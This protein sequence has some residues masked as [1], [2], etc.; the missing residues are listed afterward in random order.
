MP[1]YMYS[2]LSHCTEIAITFDTHFIMRHGIPIMRHPL[3]F[4]AWTSNS[5]SLYSHV[6]D[7]G[8]STKFIQQKC[9]SKFKL[10]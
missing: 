6:L 4:A 2:V 8:S 1:E 9:V 10:Q 7:L 5:I 3:N